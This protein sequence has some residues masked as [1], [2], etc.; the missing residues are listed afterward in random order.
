MFDIYSFI[1]YMLAIASVA[2]G[3]PAGMDGLDKRADAD[4][5]DEDRKV[6]VGVVVGAI[7]EVPREC[8]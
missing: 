6:N 1:A 5:S 4:G 7:V 8:K 3:L 2:M